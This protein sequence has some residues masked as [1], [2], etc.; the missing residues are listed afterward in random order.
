M[1]I[2][3]LYNIYSTC[4]YNISTDTRSLPEN[5]IFFALKGDNFN[6]NKFA[7]EALN[8]GATY[9]IIDEVEY[10]TG[11][12]TIF[13]DNALET[14]QQLANYHKQ[15]S[16]FSVLAITGSNGKTTTKE[17]LTCVLKKHFEVYATKGNLNNHIGV[18]LTILS[19]PKNAE[20]LILEMGANHPGEI[21]LLAE[22]ADPDY[23]LITNIGNAHIEGFGSLKGVLKAKTELFD[24]LASKDRT[25]FFNSDDIMLQSVAGIYNKNIIPY[26]FRTKETEIDASKFPFLCFNACVDNT[27]I[28][29]Q[30]NLT[31]N[32]N[33]QNIN[34]AFTVGRFFNIP[35]NTI[36]EAIS[37]YTPGNH[38]SQVKNTGNNEIIIDCYNANPSSMQ[39][40]LDNFEKIKATGKI[41]I[42]GEMKE[43]GSLSQQFHKELIEKVNKIKD[44]DKLIL[45]GKE[46]SFIE[47]NE[48]TLLFENTVEAKLY[49]KNISLKQKLVLLKG[50]RSNKLE[51]LVELL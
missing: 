19:T 1:D 51:E 10:K 49:L 48:K 21:K 20:Y 29:I 13:V 41:A 27:N 38:R 33:I 32:Y 40:A 28:L 3:S 37:K 42:L 11:D 50:S 16:K 18:P 14:L 31:G 4:N 43:L 26:S 23:G 47:P 30:S 35:I 6:G 15:Q 5:C 24:Y 44:L 9:A 34:S 39:V 45:V 7:G 17:L 2:P 22:I 25:L 8:N 46:F 12:R 36:V